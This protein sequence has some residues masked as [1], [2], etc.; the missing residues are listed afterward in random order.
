MKSVILY[1]QDYIRVGCKKGYRTAQTDSYLEPWLGDLCTSSL[2]IF[3][4]L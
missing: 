4:T 3:G 1:V 2:F